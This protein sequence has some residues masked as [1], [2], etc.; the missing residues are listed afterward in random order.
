MC[1]V[2]P[3]T[4]TAAGQRNNA[5]LNV[6]TKTAAT[7]ASNLKVLKTRYHWR[8]GRQELQVDCLNATTAWLRSV[9]SKASSFSSSTKP[10]FSALSA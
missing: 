3:G 9:R 8:A 5:L 6:A 10:P 1:A 4:W 2:S 7:R